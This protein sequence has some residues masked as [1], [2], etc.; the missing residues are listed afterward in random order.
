MCIK[1]TI[2]ILTK[3]CKKEKTKDKLNDIKDR[4][5]HS[6]QNKT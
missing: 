6:Y 3:L 1:I 5:T 4:L 2:S